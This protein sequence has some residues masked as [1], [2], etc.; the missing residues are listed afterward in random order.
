MPPW[1]GEVWARH[2]GKLVGAALGLGFGLLWRWVGF[3]RALVIALLTGAGYW[4]GHRYDQDPE[5]FLAWLERLLARR[6]G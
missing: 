2:R 4:L 3:F 6:G 1:V 5:G